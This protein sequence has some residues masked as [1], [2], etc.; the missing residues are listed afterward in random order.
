MYQSQKPAITYKKEYKSYVI[1][2]I[3]QG[4]SKI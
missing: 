3:S 4:V 2:A 1:A